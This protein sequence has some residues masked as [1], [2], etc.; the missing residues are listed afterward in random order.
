[1]SQYLLDYY[2]KINFRILQLRL[3]EFI[4][5]V[6]V[7]HYRSAH[8]SGGNTWIGGDYE[9]FVIFWFTSTSNSVI[10]LRRMKSS[11]EFSRLLE[12]LT[13]PPAYDC[14]C[15]IAHWFGHALPESLAGGRWFESSKTNLIVFSAAVARRPA[16]GVSSVHEIHPRVSGWKLNPHS[17]TP[18]FLA[19]G[20]VGVV[21]GEPM[22]IR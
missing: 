13:V 19:T 4:F 18:I 12:P 10:F 1:M 2:S 9:S 16:G 11:N 21:T 14:G 22:S 20:I 8:L 3:I 6:L 5:L 15:S 7:S 17:T